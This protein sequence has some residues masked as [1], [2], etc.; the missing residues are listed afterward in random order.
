M[1][2]AYHALAAKAPKQDEQGRASRPRPTIPARDNENPS[3]SIAN[4]VTKGAEAETISRAAITFPCS[5]PQPS[6]PNS[7]S[8]RV[9][10][11]MLSGTLPKPNIKAKIMAPG[12]EG[13]VSPASLKSAIRLAV[14]AVLR[15]RRRKSAKAV[16]GDVLAKLLA[17]YATSVTGRS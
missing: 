11:T 16:T 9:P 7:A 10:L 6:L 8:G 2:S 17:A 13:A 4:T 12:I 5:L 3:P 14:R 15:Q 1:R